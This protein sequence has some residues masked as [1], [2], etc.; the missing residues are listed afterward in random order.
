MVVLCIHSSN[1]FRASINLSDH[2]EFGFK[3]QSKSYVNI[4]VNPIDLG[5]S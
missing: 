1:V 5:D 2:R 3:R 4:R